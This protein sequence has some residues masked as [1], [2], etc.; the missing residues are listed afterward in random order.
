MKRILLTLLTLLTVM[1]GQSTTNYTK[2]WAAVKADIN[3]GNYRTA[4]AKAETLFAKAQKERQSFRILQG[5]VMLAAA[6]D[7]YEEDTFRKDLER[8]RSIAPLLDEVDAAMANLYLAACYQSFLDANRW[9]VRRNPPLA[10]P[11]DD[12]AQWD[13]QSFLDTIRALQDRTLAAEA[14][15]RTPLGSYDELLEKGNAAGQRLYP[16]LYDLAVRTIYDARSEDDDDE[17]VQMLFEQPA[18][19]GT[20]EEFL[21]LTLP[22]KPQIPLVRSLTLLQELTRFLQDDDAALRFDIDEKRTSLVRYAEMSEKVL[23]REGLERLLTAYKADD[24]RTGWYHLLA[25]YYNEL[26]QEDEDFIAYP[27]PRIKAHELCSKGIQIAPR[28]EGGIQCANLLKQIEHPSAQLKVPEVL[29]P[30]EENGGVLTARNIPQMWFRIVRSVEGQSGYD[31]NFYLRQPVLKSWTMPIDAP[32]DYDDHDTEV[33][34]PSLQPGRY[35]LLAANTASFDSRQVVCSVEM[36]V[37]ALAIVLE[38]DPQEGRVQGAVVSR[39]SGK[40]LPECQLS[41]YST[42]WKSGKRQR[43]ELLSQQSDKQGFFSLALPA[44]RS[45]LELTATDGKSTA[46][47]SLYPDSKHSF[48]ANRRITLFSDRYSYRPGDEVQFS[49]VCYNEEDENHFSVVAGETVT[50]ELRDVNGKVVET[51]EGTTDEYGCVQGTFRL[52]TTML[53]GRVSLHAYADAH[54]SRYLNLEAY[55]QPTFAIAFEE[56]PDHIALTDTVHV[57]GSAISYTAVPVQG[58]TVS[59]VVTR[60]EIPSHYWWYCYGKTK[61]VARA[62]VQTDGDGSFHFDLQPLF[63]RDSEKLK[64]RCYRYEIE[65]AITAID[66]ETQSQR[67]SVRVGHPYEAPKDDTPEG[68]MPK[69]ALLWGYQPAKSVEAGETALLKIGTTKQD[70]CV[71]WFL[72]KG[73][74]V[75]DHGTMRL[76]KGECDWTLHTDDSWKGGFTLRLVTYKD[77]KME[78]RSFFFDVPH[79]ERELGIT[80]TTFRDRLNPGEPERWTLHVADNGRQPVEANIVAALYDAALDVY[81]TNSWTLAPW[82]DYRMSNTLAERDYTASGNATSPAIDYRPVPI[83]ALPQLLYLNAASYVIGLESRVAGFGRSRM[84]MSAAPKNMLKEVAMTGEV[85]AMADDAAVMEEAAVTESAAMANGAADS[86]E[87]EAGEAPANVYIRQDLNH[88]AFFQPCVRTDREGNAEISFTAP[89]L[90]TEWNFQGV[91]FT[92]DLRVG[93]FLQSVVTRKELMVQPNLPRFLRQG[94]R[95]AFTAK[96]T[97]LSEA[98]MEA[99]VRLEL[100]DART[101]KPLRSFKAKAQK[102]VVAKGGVEAVAFEVEVPDDVFAIQ[103]L[104]TAEGASHSDGE[105]GVIAVLSNRTLVTQ[106]MAMYANA[107]EK[108]TYTFDDLAESRISS[109]VSHKLSLEYTSSPIWYAIQTLP[110]L[111][112][113]TNPSNEQLFHRFYAN[114]L[115]R[116]IL[117]AHPQIEPIF[118]RWA[119]ETPDAFLSQLE[120]NN[121]LKQIVLSETPWMVQAE[122]ETADRRR[123]ADFFDRQ[124][125]EEAL[126]TLRTQLLKNQ[127]AD[128]GWS[129]MPDYESSPHITMLILQGMGELRSMGCLDNDDELNAALRKALVYT[130]DVYYKEYL[131]WLKEEAKVSNF[132]KKRRLAPICINYLYMRSWWTDVPL[133]AKTKTSYNYFYGALKRVSHTDDTLMAKALTALTFHRNGDD[134]LAADI[135]RLLGESALFSDEMGMYWRDNQSGMFWYNAPVETQS[136]L[137]RAYY[138]C[139]ANVDGEGRPVVALMQ[140]WLLKQKQT[141]HWGNSVATAHAVGAL[142]LGDGQK[143]LDSTNVAVLTIGGKHVEPENAEAGTG[144]FRKDWEAADIRRSMGTVTIDNSANASCSWGAVYW[145]YF[146]DIDKMPLAETGFDVKAYYYKVQDDGS[147]AAIDGPLQVGDKVRVRLRFTTDR[148]LDYVQVKA[149]RAAGLEPVGTRSGRQ[150]NGLSYYLAVEDAA[151]TLYVD[152]MEKGD[153]TVEFDCWATLPGTFLSGTVTLQC[154]YAPEFRATFSQPNLTIE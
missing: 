103:Y 107:G 34:I 1:A 56:F 65:V 47:R 141:T 33:T 106:S 127:N 151:T 73:L 149:H 38:Q 143:T 32:H 68:V 74:E 139:G 83:V 118:R 4:H 14:L 137:I 44:E 72:E 5:A 64:D 25:S 36:T 28:S 71:V 109:L 92:K 13:E 30:D 115:T 3:N 87:A 75:V 17:E 101:G 111:D 124:R 6:I 27:Q 7:E 48:S 121:D 138:E 61:T 54:A 21:Q 22:Q 125:T 126:A 120:K 153:Y 46:E 31:L 77:N 67:T 26:Q 128:G 39:K 135:V 122:T 59:Y 50:V 82:H 148:A 76:S 55:K 97:N 10:E 84:L 110:A 62:T 95:F 129:W 88:T 90:L 113:A 105:K 23:Y 81:G 45:S 35:V 18:L 70:V 152:R 43:T 140:Q 42:R 144:Y 12:L 96:V 19:Y 15:R 131:E 150:W 132:W 123:V 49:L 79:R 117:E 69:D 11:T 130:D 108:K 37:S 116:S 99:K 94:D 57:A 41:L 98:D 91:A 112:E 60:Q 133:T 147:L 63:S 136:L 104:I 86:E 89:D 114:S 16:T 51:F 100:T 9:T 85:M 80:L 119:D 58:A 78:E 8:Y 66:G 145:Q 52:G 93:Q 146:V 24:E 40:P 142:L 53:P 2:E 102:V 29:L 154:L 20:A 134:K